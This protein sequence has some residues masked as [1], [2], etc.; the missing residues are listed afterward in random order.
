M[1]DDRVFHT[2]WQSLPALSS[3]GLTFTPENGK[4]LTPLTLNTLVQVSNGKLD[5]MT[6]L[7]VVSWYQWVEQ[8]GD[9]GT[10]LWILEHEGSGGKGTKIDTWSQLIYIACILK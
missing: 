1:C 9:S 2:L 8:F 5:Q 7:L 6:L 3:M 10:H 4:S